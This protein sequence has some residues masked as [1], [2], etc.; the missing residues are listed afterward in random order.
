MQQLHLGSGLEA[1][2]AHQDAARPAIGRQRISLPAR[3]VQ[4][5]HEL[6]VE[7]LA[8]RVLGGE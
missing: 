6:A 5:H 7:W 2:L 1:K 4:R 8:E 3:P